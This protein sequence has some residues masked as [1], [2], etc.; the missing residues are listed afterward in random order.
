MSNAP[1]QCIFER[2]MEKASLNLRHETTSE[3]EVMVNYC[4]N[5]R[6]YVDTPGF[7]DSDEKKTMRQN[8]SQ[9]EYYD[10]N[11]WDNVIIVHKGIDIEQGPYDA[12]KEIA[13]NF[14]QKNHKPENDAKKNL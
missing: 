2:A 7:D 10:G 3:T 5:G 12:A 8:S 1:Q 11:V 14:Y 9:E 4:G 13:R 6:F